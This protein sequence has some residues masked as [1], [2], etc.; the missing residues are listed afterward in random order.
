MWESIIYNLLDRECFKSKTKETSKQLRT[1]SI[2]LAQAQAQWLPFIESNTTE[3]EWNHIKK[4][5]VYK[6]K[7]GDICLVAASRAIKKDLL[8][9]NTNKTTSTEPMTL[10]GAK[11]YEGG[12]LT[13]INPVLMGYNGTHFESLETMSPEDDI[14]AIELVNLIKSNKY[15]LNKTHI[16]S[17]AR[18]SH[19]KPVTT[20]K[21]SAD[22][23]GQSRGI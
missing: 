12:Q 23:E 15:I 14:R 1:R 13:D 19:N 17:M 22:K 7:L 11:D 20:T 4:D 2:N 3:E 5:K 16:Q 21:E 8:I 6:T 18:V 10:I 9:F